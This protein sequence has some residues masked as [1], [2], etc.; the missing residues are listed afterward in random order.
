LAS[1]EEKSALI[2]GFQ[3]QKRGQYFIG[4]HNVTLPVIAMRISNP[5]RSPLAIH[6]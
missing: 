2:A 1:S 3:F 4:V 5:D 6:G